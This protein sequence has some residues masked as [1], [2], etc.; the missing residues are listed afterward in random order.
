MATQRFEPGVVIVVLVV[1]CEEIW[2][3]FGNC[4]TNLV[5]LPILTEVWTTA[6]I[7]KTTTWLLRDASFEDFKDG[8]L[9][10]LF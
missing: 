4:D 7:M 5:T 9:L 3:R 10:T 6:E 1:P 8:G 2:I